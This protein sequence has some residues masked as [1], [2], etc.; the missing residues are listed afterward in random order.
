MST[1][2]PD[3]T[4]RTRARAVELSGSATQEILEP[5]DEAEAVRIS[6]INNEPM[7]EPKPKYIR[8]RGEKVIKNGNTFIVLGRDRPGGRDSG[9]GGAGHS[10]ASAFRVSTGMQCSPIDGTLNYDPNFASDAATLY[11]SQK[12]DM[13][14]A[15]NTLG[16][17]AVPGR[18]GAGLKAD[19]VRLAGRDSIQLVTR[20]EETNSRGGATSYGGISLVACNDGASMEPMVKGSALVS[21]LKKISDRLDDLATQI[22]NNQ[23]AL[24]DF[25]IELAK[26]THPGFFPV[27]PSPELLANAFVITF[28]RF[29]SVFNMFKFRINK[30][31]DRTTT[32][33]GIGT[34][35]INSRYNKVN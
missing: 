9:F 24:N 12:T 19:V 28:E 35:Y 27:G 22:D 1:P 26:H 34:G 23:R 4:T 20:T 21:A 33:S 29:E 15:F 30:E 10:G 16:S 7:L 13:D 25:Q 14:R 2:L 17:A 32:T 8:A 18:S 5:R 3:A 11:I 6:G 31:M